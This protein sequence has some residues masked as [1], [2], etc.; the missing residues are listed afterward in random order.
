MIGDPLT[1]IIIY[2]FLVAEYRVSIDKY[3]MLFFHP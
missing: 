1:V 3:R 2:C